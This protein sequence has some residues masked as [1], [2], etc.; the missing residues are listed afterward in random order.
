MQNN[1]HTPSLISIR[2][3][4]YSF[5]KTEVIVLGTIQNNQL[6]E[7]YATVIMMEVWIA[8][9][10]LLPPVD[11]VDCESST[12][13]SLLFSFEHSVSGDWCT[14]EESVLL[15][16]HPDFLYIFGCAVY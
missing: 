9:P 13:I 4:R 6:T 1:A 11:C 15:F 7:C 14:P 16:R 2:R 12:L 5:K 10:C 8:I 3:V